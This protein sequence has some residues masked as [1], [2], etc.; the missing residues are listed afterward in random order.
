VAGK[1]KK[2]GK[3]KCPHPCECGWR[4]RWTASA[5]LGA[6]ALGVWES[7]K[8]ELK[9]IEKRLR[10]EALRGEALAHLLSQPV[11]AHVYVKKLRKTFQARR[12]YF[13]RATARGLYVVR[14][15]ICR[16]WF[17]A[18]LPRTDSTYKRKKLRV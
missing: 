6:R 2:R 16:V 9:D 5:R 4:V 12:Y 10:D 7:V 14:T 17:V 8:A 3:K 18:V 13:G 15:E 11:V 1:R